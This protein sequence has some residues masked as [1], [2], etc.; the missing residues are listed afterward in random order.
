MYLAAMPAMETY[1][2]TTAAAVQVTMVM[3]LG[4]FA[5]GQLLWGPITDRFG[6][7]KPTYVGL[8]IFILSSASC[9]F[10][11]SIGVMSA[12]RLF[13]AVGACSGSVISRAI[14]RDLFPPSQL[15]KIFSILILV[16]GVS[17]VIAPTIGSYLLE[18]FGWRSSFVAQASV[19]TLC[20]IGMH[21][22]LSESMDFRRRRP[23]QLPLILS[24]YGALLRDRTFLGA[25]VV[26]GFSSAGV[27]AYIAASPF[28][29]IDYYG[30]SNRVFGWLF[31]AIAAGMVVTSQI[32]GNLPDRFRIWRILRAANLVQLVAGVALLA[33]V[34][35][36]WGGV[37][38]VFGGV[39]VYVAAQ[40]FVF[41]NGSAIA[42]TR[43]P[44]I[45]G[46]ASALL[47]T[48][49]FLIAAIATSLLGY[50]ENPLIPMAVLIAAS[51]LLSTLLNYATLGA[52]LETMPE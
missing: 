7:K 4:G 50:L 37:P 17:P 1:F 34:L 28:V 29:F 5:L 12:L 25:S 52:R 26:C 33:A 32:N 27:F 21:F 6:R 13:Q 49:Q 23:L 30:V 45:A 14:V 24:A 3:F 19:G 9:A 46:S 8:V 2:A 39:F 10:A 20:L 51:A 16:L 41:P 42:M 44:E 40:G 48:N 47:G 18:W 43:H 22:R 38:A 36:G 35:T 11:P 15:R 31:G